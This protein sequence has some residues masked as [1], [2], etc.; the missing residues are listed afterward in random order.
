MMLKIHEFCE[1]IKKAFEK[2]CFIINQ[3]LFWELTTQNAD[4]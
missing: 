1:G 3:K 2:L 4:M